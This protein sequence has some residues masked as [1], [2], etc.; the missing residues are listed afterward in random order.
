MFILLQVRGNAGRMPLLTMHSEDGRVPW[1][2]DCEDEAQE[3]FDKLRM[4]QPVMGVAE[5]VSKTVVDRSHICP[6][7]PENGNGNGNGGGED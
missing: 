2:T 5:F 3:M 1:E 7:P 4:T 6:D